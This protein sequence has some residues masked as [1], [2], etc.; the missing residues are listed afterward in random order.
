MQKACLEHGSDLA[1][2]YDR[3]GR[4]LR[5]RRLAIILRKKVYTRDLFR[6]D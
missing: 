1:S 3:W 5:G 2:V 6:R 4:T